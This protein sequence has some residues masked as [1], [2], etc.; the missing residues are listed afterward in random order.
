VNGRIEVL[1]K[2]GV[3]NPNV[4]EVAEL[5]ANRLASDPRAVV[6]GK[7]LLAKARE[8]FRSAKGVNLKVGGASPT[9]ANAVL[10]NIR[11]LQK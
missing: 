7:A 8:R 9:L 4:G 6:K 11:K 2:N 3:T 1:R 5:A 10:K